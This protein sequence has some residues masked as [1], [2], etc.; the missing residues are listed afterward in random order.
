MEIS[1]L[2]STVQND[3]TDFDEP[4]V[5]D[6]SILFTIPSHDEQ[7]SISFDISYND[8]PLQSNEHELNEENE[9]SKEPSVPASPVK[10]HKS[11]QAKHNKYA[12]YAKTENIILI[13]QW[14]MK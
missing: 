6:T 9:T 13:F 1:P 3:T 2:N 7:E 8:V 14:H 11:T 4:L 5:G 12:L 10:T